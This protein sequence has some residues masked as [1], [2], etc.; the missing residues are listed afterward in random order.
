MGYTN[1]EI[2]TKLEAIRDAILDDLATD[3]GPK[4]RVASYS[5]GGRSFSYSTRDG[6]LSAFREVEAMLTKYRR[7]GFFQLARVMPTSG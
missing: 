2:V 6:A 3:T 5:V 4:F 7:T 1:A